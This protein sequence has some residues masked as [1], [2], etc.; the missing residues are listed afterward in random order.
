MQSLTPYNREG[1]DKTSAAE[2]AARRAYLQSQDP[3][4]W[5]VRVSRGHADITVGP[6]EARAHWRGED[7]E[8]LA[9]VFYDNILYAAI[10][11]LVRMRCK[12]LGSE[13]PSDVAGIV[14]VIVDHMVA[15]GDFVGELQREFG[16]R[17]VSY[18]N[19]YLSKT[20][21]K[22]K[23]YPVLVTRTACDALLRS[24]LHPTPRDFERFEYK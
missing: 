7:V 11:K 6:S 14:G 15:V 18:A 5:T 24:R 21:Y 3:R 16:V 1:A 23:T 4:D 10:P 20:F 22:T 12:H 17:A 8:W 19:W 9:I 2:E 13:V